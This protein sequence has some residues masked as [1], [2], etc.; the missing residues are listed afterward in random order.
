MASSPRA[1]AAPIATIPV[2]PSPSASRTLAVG[3][4][5]ALA[6][7]SAVASSRRSHRGAK[8]SRK[9]GPAKKELLLMRL[10][11]EEDESS[12]AG[13]P[14]APENRIRTPLQ[15]LEAENTKLRAEVQKL[16]L[17]M[18]VMTIE[19]R[20]SNERAETAETDL[21]LATDRQMISEADEQRRIRKSKERLESEVEWYSQELDHERRD[22][23]MAVKI[24]KTKAE[25]DLR[26]GEMSE[27]TKHQVIHDL[28]KEVES[29]RNAL[30]RA[31]AVS[32]RGSECVRV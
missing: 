22:A 26:R 6:D 10:P 29:L 25:E 1:A 2:N 31:N 13:A 20:A 8:A 32:V 21:Q 16:T 12:S 15:D 11:E 19:M 24:T 18:A 5:R 23:A 3:K 17:D 30:T 27:Q 4:A 28:E 14:S 9:A 7:K